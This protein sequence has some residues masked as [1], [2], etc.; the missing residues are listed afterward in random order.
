[1]TNSTVIIY[2][3]NALTNLCEKINTGLVNIEKVELEDLEKINKY[4][5]KESKLRK[6]Y[7]LWKVAF[8][9]SYEEFVKSQCYTKEEQLECSRAYKRLIKICDAI[10]EAIKDSHDLH[11]SLSDHTFIEVCSKPNSWSG[12]YSNAA[13]R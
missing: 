2:K 3:Y 13:L 10:D 7:R 9:G 5:F 11:L 12:T 1:M 6:W 8:T 4:R